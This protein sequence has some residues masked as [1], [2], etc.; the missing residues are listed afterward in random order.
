MLS[1][2]QE[3]VSLRKGKTKSEECG[4]ET[5]ATGGQ[6]GVAVQEIRRRHTYIEI[7]NTRGGG[8]GGGFPQLIL[9]QCWHMD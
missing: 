2:E 3:R 4:D 7:Y 5:A 6:R 8:G 9:W 1:E